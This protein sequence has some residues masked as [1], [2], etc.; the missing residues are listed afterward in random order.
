VCAGKNISAVGQYSGSI[1]PDSYSWQLQSC[2]SAGVTT[3]AYDSG[4]LN[5]AGAPSGPFTFPNTANLACNQY[6][7]ITLTV[8]KNCPD[9]VTT[10]VTKILYVNC[11]PSLVT[12]GNTTI[13]HGHSTTLCANYQNNSQYTVEWIYH[14]GTAVLDVDAQCITVSPTTNTTY[15]LTVTNNATGCKSTKNIAVTVVKANPE[16][17]YHTNYNSPNPYF[18][19]SATPVT[20]YSNGVAGFGDLWIIEQLDSSG[21]PIPNTNTSTG[22]PGNPICWWIYPTVH[23]FNGFDGTKS[24]GINNVTCPSPSPGRFLNGGTYRITHGIWNDYCPWSQASHTIT[25][26]GNRNSGRF[27]S[28]EDKSKVNVPDYRYLKPSSRSNQ[29]GRP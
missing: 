10:K 29:N 21:N 22:N 11:N 17:T 3:S 24:S 14:A 7:L 5:F 1:P 20:P 25:V 23:A 9:P 2:T 26:N 15:N 8:K 16:F 28:V 19:V 27:T 18:T 12:T 13:C 6:Y 4:V